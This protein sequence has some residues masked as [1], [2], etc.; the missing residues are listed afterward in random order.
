MPLNGIGLNIIAI[1]FQ[2]EVSVLWLWG[3]SGYG[4][5]GGGDAKNVVVFSC[6]FEGVYCPQKR[7]IT[8][9][10]TRDV[11]IMSFVCIIMLR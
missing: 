8:N 3:G 9:I 5:G 11:R 2:M 1:L 10:M 7:E 4:F 6:H